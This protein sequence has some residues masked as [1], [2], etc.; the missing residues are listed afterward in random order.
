MMIKHYLLLITVLCCFQYASAQSFPKQLA[1]RN[2]APVP[3]PSEKIILN[4]GSS[5]SFKGIQFYGNQA[6]FLPSAKPALDSLLVVMQDNPSLKIE[7]QGHVNGPHL[8]N[9]SYLMDLSNQRAEAV[10][11]FLV[12]NKI[13]P[14]RLVYRGYSNTKMLF[15][16]PRSLDEQ[17]QNRRVEIKVISK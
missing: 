13:S 11:T 9:S 15:P 10:Y 8:A 4:V 2:L 1:V 16:Q 5:F 17:Q 6:T 12:R 7:I 3:T 14:T